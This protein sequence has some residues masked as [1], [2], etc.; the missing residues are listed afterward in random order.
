[1]K[2]HLRMIIKVFQKNK[3]KSF[4]ATNLWYNIQDETQQESMLVT[5]RIV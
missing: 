2:R 4:Q 5:N 1:M 3:E